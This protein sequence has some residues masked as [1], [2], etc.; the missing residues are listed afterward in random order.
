MGP[1]GS[2]LEI[3]QGAAFPFGLGRGSASRLIEE[4]HGT[5][6][7]SY[8][9]PCSSAA[10]TELSTPPDMAATTRSPGLSFG[11]FLSDANANSRRGEVRGPL[12]AIPWEML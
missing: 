5:P 6:I 11:W 12:I 4:L 8:P 1:P 9:A 7:T 10:M 3:I 2:I